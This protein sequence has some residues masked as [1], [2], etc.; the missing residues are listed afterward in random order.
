MHT[1]L[2]KKPPQVFESAVF[3]EFEWKY[4]ICLNLN[5]GGW[6]LKIIS[7]SYCNDLALGSVGTYFLEV[8]AYASLKGAT[9]GVW[10]C[11]FCW[12]WVKIRV[13]LNRAPTSIHLH[14]SPPSS[15]QLHPPPLSSF[16]SPPSSLQRP[17]QYLNQ[18]IARN[19]AISSNLGQKIKS[20]PFWLKIGT[21]GILEVLIPNPDL[22]FWNSDPKIHF[23][24]NLG[25]K[26]QSCPFCLKIGAHSIS[27]ML[28]P[29]PD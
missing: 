24:A 7:F 10:E 17:Q 22:D 29:N 27:R 20:C 11:C 6:D 3:A 8:G 5:T 15:T 12:N 25:P 28:I 9:V 4:H 19:W 26:S 23:W 13:L 16:E 2:W 21:H 14:S 18:N 1:C